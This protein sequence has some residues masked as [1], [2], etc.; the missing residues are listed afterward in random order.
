MKGG[1]VS[2]EGVDVTGVEVWN[3]VVGCHSGGGVVSHE[4]GAVTYPD[5]VVNAAG[6]ATAANVDGVD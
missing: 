3:G 5:G 2:H 6:A 1:V 4:G